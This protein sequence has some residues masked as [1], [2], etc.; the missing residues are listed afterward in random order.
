LVDKEEKGN[1]S[2]SKS[3]EEPLNARGIAANTR[4]REPGYGFVDAEKPEALLEGN[5]PKE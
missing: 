4:G 5:R 2:E 3:M 1:S